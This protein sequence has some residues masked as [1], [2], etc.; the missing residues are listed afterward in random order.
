MNRRTFLL[1]AMNI[2]AVGVIGQAVPLIAATGARAEGRDDFS[3]LDQASQP[4]TSDIVRRRI[5]KKMV[6]Y[7]G[8]ERPG[9]IIVDTGERALTFVLE[10]GKA[11]RYPVGV[12]RQGFSWAGKAHIRRKAEWPAW[13]PPQT[14]RERVYRQTGKQLP[15]RMEG[16]LNN[17]LGAR[18]LYLY[19]G[20]RDTLYRIHGTN[21]P[22]SIGRAM[23]S[24]CIRMMN[25]EVIDLYERVRLG[26]RVTVV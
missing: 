4:S 7:S 25:E 17:P 23:S 26:A 24:G 15:V 19:Q 12:G 16:G 8:P 5:G 22:N 21:D 11:L 14:M 6:P 10:D 9:S 1:G 3:V 18:A 20:G 2:G 13:H